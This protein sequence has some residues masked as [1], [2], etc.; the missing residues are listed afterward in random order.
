MSSASGFGGA[1]ERWNHANTRCPSLALRAAYSPWQ[2][3]AGQRSRKQL[4][5]A[6]AEKGWGSAQTWSAL[7]WFVLPPPGRFPIA[8]P[9][10]ARWHRTSV[11]L[12]DHERTSMRGRW[13]VA[14]EE[15]A[16]TTVQASALG[17][18][19]RPQRDATRPLVA[20]SDRPPSGLHSMGRNPCAHPP[21]TPPGSVLGCSPDTARPTTAGPRGSQQLLWCER[22]QSMSEAG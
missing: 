3:W 1:H 14:S 15:S 10:G 16:A 5:E 21:P 13:P 4:E 18:L 6:S 7:Q 19:P 17:R 2:P 20:V 12:P 9:Q 11:P 22:A 8:R